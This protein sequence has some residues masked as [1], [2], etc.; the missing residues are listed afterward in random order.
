MD[1]QLL[2]GIVSG[3]HSLSFEC[4][5]LFRFSLIDALSDVAEVGRHHSVDTIL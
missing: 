1:P 3:L 5:E 4:R 2:A